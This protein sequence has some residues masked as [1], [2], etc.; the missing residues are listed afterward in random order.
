MSSGW[1]GQTNDGQ[2]KAYGPTGYTPNYGGEP[3]ASE[4]TTEWAWRVLSL[5]GRI[6]FLLLHGGTTKECAGE[7]GRF[8]LQF[9]SRML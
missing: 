9:L 6:V 1:D 2:E 3:N 8:H 4:T 5:H 7:F